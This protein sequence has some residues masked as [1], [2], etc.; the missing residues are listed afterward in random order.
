MSYDL[1]IL[2]QNQEEPSV[3]PFPSL[4]QMMNEKDDGIAR[5]H[6][7]W[8]YMTQSKGIWY[9]LVKERNGML[10]AFPI[11]D[12][13]FEA[14]ETAIE[15]PYWITDDSIK[16]NLTPLIIYEEYRRDFEKIIKYLIKQSPTK[17][18]M[19]LACYQGGEHEIV[20]GILRCK[21]FIKLLN[22]SKILF[23]IC[24]IISD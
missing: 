16:Y 13:K 24:Y 11:C 2:V 1:N 21:E 18:V 19:F 9:S 7:I 5:Y 3:L 23:N 14:N 20:C 4:I 15:I 17:T 10:N 12:S 22:Q 8:R 6:S